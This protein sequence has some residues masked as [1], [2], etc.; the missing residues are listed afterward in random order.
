MKCRKQTTSLACALWLLL[1]KKTEPQGNAAYFSRN[2]H[3]E[4]INSVFDFVPIFLC[5]ALCM[6]VKKS[7]AKLLPEISWLKWH[8]PVLIRFLSHIN[9]HNVTFNQN[10]K[11]NSRYADDVYNVEIVLIP[12][13]G[14][15]NEHISFAWNGFASKQ[16]NTWIRVTHKCFEF[17]SCIRFQCYLKL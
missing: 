6:N 10:P 12:S 3:R 1:N 16:K 7:K 4:L 11:I 15:T 2:I 17:W 14:I 8:V 9:L 5:T 13:Y